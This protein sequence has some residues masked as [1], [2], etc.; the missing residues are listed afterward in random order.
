MK[1]ELSKRFNK[2]YKKLDNKQA[3][4]VFKTLQMFLRDKN[5]TTL[6]YH[7]LKGQWADH[8][9]ISADG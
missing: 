1:L 8:Y 6:R 3:E 2:Q 7:A 9:S 5:T 4:R